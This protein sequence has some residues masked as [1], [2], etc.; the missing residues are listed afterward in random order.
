MAKQL[1][2]WE[3]PFSRAVKQK[4]PQQL[5]QSIGLL[6]SKPPLKSHEDHSLTYLFVLEVNKQKLGLTVCHINHLWSTMSHLFFPCSE[7]PLLFIP[8]Q[9]K[10][11]IYTCAKGWLTVPVTWTPNAVCRPHPCYKTDTIIWSAHD[12]LSITLKTSLPN[13]SKW[14]FCH[15]FS[16]FAPAAESCS[17]TVH[18]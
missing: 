4:M 9:A 6:V 12:P 10:S 5:P 15:A 17:A 18:A 11:V 7:K 13:C 8:Y 3:G 16:V 14:F 2:C 1:P